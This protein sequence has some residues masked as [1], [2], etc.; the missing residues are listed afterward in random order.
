MLFY[1]FRVKQVSRELLGKIKKLKDWD[2]QVIN[3]R[4]ILLWYSRS[5]PVL[6]WKQQ[7]LIKA[8]NVC[9]CVNI[10]VATCCLYFPIGILAI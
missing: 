7:H 4:L 3:C 9:V 6:S 2:T 5:I 8:P 1:L 10:L